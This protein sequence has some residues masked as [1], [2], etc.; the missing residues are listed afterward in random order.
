[1][2]IQDCTMGKIVQELIPCTST[3]GGTR[4][5]RIGH[6]TGLAVNNTAWGETIPVV[7][8]AQRQEPGALVP[9]IAQPEMVHHAL[10]FDMDIKDFG[11]RP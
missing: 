10:L 9:V 8:F 1:M 3:P 6:I 11:C 2:R 5:G 7:V 4:R